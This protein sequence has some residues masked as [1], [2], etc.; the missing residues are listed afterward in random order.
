M[1]EKKHLSS[2]F[3]LAYCCIYS[4]TANPMKPMDNN[5][6]HAEIV[7]SVEEIIA[8]M[9][10]SQIDFEG[11]DHDPEQILLLT[12]V[13]SKRFCVLK[14]ADD[15]MSRNLLM[16][17]QPLAGQAESRF[18][19]LLEFVSNIKA[20]TDGLAAEMSDIST[21]IN[22]NLQLMLNFISDG[23]HGYVYLHRQT[24]SGDAQKFPLL[25]ELPGDQYKN[26]YTVEFKKHQHLIRYYLAR[27][28]FH[29]Y[30]RYKGELYKPMFITG[31]HIFTHYFQHQSTIKEFIHQE[32]YPFIEN[33]W[34]WPCLT[35]LA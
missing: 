10:D 3:F 19:S 24:F 26:A 15:A 35:Q 25:G 13:I 17:G 28:K 21:D 5:N 20:F 33:Q 34:L 9:L 32:C 30:R 11:E 6:N 1:G 23:Y 2:F 29:Q 31:R 16:F 22:K 18:T 7:L 14:N 8:Y 4:S 12:N 27:A